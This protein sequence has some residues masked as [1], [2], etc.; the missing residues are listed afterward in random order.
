MASL[1]T[2]GIDPKVQDLLKRAADGVTGGGNAP[3]GTGTYVSAERVHLTQD[4]RPVGQ[5]DPDAAFLLCAAG[6]TL[7][8]DLADE[9]GLGPSAPP[10]PKTSPARGS[11]K[12]TVADPET[13][14]TKTTDSGDL[15]P[16]QVA[17]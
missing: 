5:D 4:G 7:P 15:D 10:L 3:A 2:T 16:G 11:L 1:D 14:Q 8:Q 13:G 12:I 9:L 17:S 6:A